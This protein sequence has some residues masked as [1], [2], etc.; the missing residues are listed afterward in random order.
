MAFQVLRILNVENGTLVIGCQQPSASRF[1][2]LN[3]SQGHVG[4]AQDGAMLVALP[5]GYEF[6]ALVE[7][8]RVVQ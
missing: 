5:H 6:V 4:V 2:G 7:E 1:A 8:Q 3:L